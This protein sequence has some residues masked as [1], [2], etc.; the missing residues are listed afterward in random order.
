MKSW[1]ATKIAQ[2]FLEM[3][4]KDPMSGYF[5]MWRK[6]FCAIQGDLHVRGINILLEILGVKVMGKCRQVTGMESQ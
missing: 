3:E 5:L 2:W 4:L 6:D 1:I